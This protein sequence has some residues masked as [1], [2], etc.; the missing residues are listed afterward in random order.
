MVGQVPRETGA[1]RHHSSEDMWV[2]LRDLEIIFLPS[3]IECVDRVLQVVVPRTVPAHQHLES[4]VGHCLSTSRTT[5]GTHMLADH[6]LPVEGIHCAGELHAPWP[7]NT[8]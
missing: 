7:G 3:R 4:S 2:H 8:L 5:G 6:L 1:V